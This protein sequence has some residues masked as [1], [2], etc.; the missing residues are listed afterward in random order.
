MPPI[1][2]TTPMTGL[3]GDAEA[4]LV[5]KA[6]AMALKLNVRMMFLNMSPPNYAWSW[7]QTLESEYWKP[8]FDS[9]LNV[10]KS[11]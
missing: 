3:S 4:R 11:I 2:T 7:H 8:G 9:L 5:A 10:A 6:K 1:F